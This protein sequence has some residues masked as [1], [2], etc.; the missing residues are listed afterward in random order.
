VL[1]KQY[2][3]QIHGCFGYAAMTGDADDAMQNVA[4]FLNRVWTVVQ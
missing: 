3:G 4:E 2:A 1:R